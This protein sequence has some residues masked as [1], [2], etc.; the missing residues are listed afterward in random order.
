M[1]GDKSLREIK[2][3]LWKAFAADGRDPIQALDA[4]IQRLNN[5][6]KPKQNG[7][8]VLE[9]IKRLLQEHELT[10]SRRAK[11]TLRVARGRAA[12]KANKPS[13]T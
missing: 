10:S 7:T 4:E 9:A 8:E 12:T 11:R 13:R 3:E 1:M 2:E 5:Q 6:R